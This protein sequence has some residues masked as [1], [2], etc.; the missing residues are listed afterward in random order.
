MFEIQP[1]IN[2][3]ESIKFRITSLTLSLINSKQSKHATPDLKIESFFKQ[4]IKY[5][6]QTHPIYKTLNLFRIPAKLMEIKVSPDV[7]FIEF[8]INFYKSN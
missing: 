4:T 3:T 2:H 7:Y 5:E 8:V 6:Y 1:Y